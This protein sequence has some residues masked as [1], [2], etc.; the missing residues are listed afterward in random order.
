MLDL[1]PFL[2]FDGN[3]SE[4]MR[5]YQQCLGGDLSVTM[6]ADTPMGADAPPEHRHKVAYAHLQS[7]AIALSATDWQHPTRAPMPGNTVAMYL[8]GTAAELRSRFASLAAGGDP[9]LL[10]DLRELPF[11]LYGHFADRYGVHWFFRGD[12]A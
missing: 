5:F 11:G 8:T 7:G 10:D 1:T 3:C 2:L 6:V 12:L 4:A 9:E